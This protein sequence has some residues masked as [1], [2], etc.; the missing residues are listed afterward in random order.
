ML[1]WFFCK[2]NFKKNTGFTGFT[3]FTGGFCGIPVSTQNYAL[4]LIFKYRLFES[5][6]FTSTI[7]K[8]QF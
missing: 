4:G 8:E 7:P 1:G 5:D 2:I 6:Q 3:G